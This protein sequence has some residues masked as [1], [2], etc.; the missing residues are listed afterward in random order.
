M[1]RIPPNFFMR[2]DLQALLLKTHGLTTQL[3]QDHE[4]T[5]VL[6]ALSTAVA[7]LEGILADEPFHGELVLQNPNNWKTD[8][9]GGSYTVADFYVGYAR[10]CFLTPN[11]TWIGTGRLRLTF[12]DG[13]VHTSSD[14]AYLRGV[15]LDYMQKKNVTE[16][17]QRTLLNGVLPRYQD[18]LH[19]VTVQV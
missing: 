2:R 1:A 19:P 16:A 9:M 14:H 4:L 11:G 18:E 10:Q 15:L 6:R 7:N 8:W 12:G 5:G 13:E 3:D 17:N